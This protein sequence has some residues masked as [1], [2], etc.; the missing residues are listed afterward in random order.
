MIYE[1]GLVI[2]HSKI[3]IKSDRN[4]AILEA[5]KGIKHHIKELF[6]YVKRNPLFQYSLEPIDVDSDAPLIAKLMCEASR[7]AGVGP[8][9]SVAGT[10]ADIGLKILLDKGA[11]TA[12][13]ENGGEISAYTSSEEIVVSIITGEVSLSG[14][15]GLVISKDN[16]PLGIGTSSGKTVQIVSFGEAD[17]VTV[18]A[19]NAALADAAATAVCNAVTG[20]HIQRSV[21]KGLERARSI[22]GVKAA[23]IVREGYVGLI[24]EL[25]RIVRIK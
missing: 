14:K 5:I 3:H 15:M 25:P 2:G 23:I 10:I 7:A 9:A 18:I 11:N 12:L 6:E 22:K 19:E 17:S 24:G 1:S 13:I 20:S 16:S 8:M 4:E 21:F